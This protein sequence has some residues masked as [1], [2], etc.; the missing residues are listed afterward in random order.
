MQQTIANTFG[1]DTSSTELQNLVN[2]AG[3]VDINRYA[4]ATQRITYDS[5]GEHSYSDSNARE[6][7][8]HP[9]VQE[10]SAALVS[11]E[12]LLT[13]KNVDLLDALERLVVVLHGVRVTFCKSGKDRT[14]MVITLEQAKQLTTCYGPACSSSSSPAS[15]SYSSSSSSSTTAAGFSSTAVSGGQQKEKELSDERLLQTANLLRIHGTRLM[16]AEKNIGRSVYSINLLQARF[17]PPFLRP[18]PSVCEAMLK[19]DN[20]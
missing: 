10:L 13:L 17:L 1:S 9:L 8:T 19:K 14:G 11:S 2:R 3:Y 6:L 20:S 15:S 12:E 18:P 4:H 16:V 5:S 7:P